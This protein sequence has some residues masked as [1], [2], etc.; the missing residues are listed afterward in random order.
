ME[1]LLEFSEFI[2]EEKKCNVRPNELKPGDS[3]E[4]INPNCKHY[5]SKGKVTQVK[6]I[7]NKNND[8]GRKIEYQIKNKGKKFN[9]G[10]KIEK[11][12]I[13]LRKT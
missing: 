6:K 1:H 9:K 10:E 7:K 13:Q 8:V 12:E 4:N 3:V 11:T 2:N 5:K